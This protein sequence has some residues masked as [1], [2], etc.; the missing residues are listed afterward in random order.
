MTDKIT[1]FFFALF[2]RG[3]QQPIFYPFLRPHSAGQ[4]L[5]LVRLDLHSLVEQRITEIYMIE[6]TVLLFPCS[7]VLERILDGD[8]VRADRREYFPRK[9]QIFSEQLRIRDF[10]NDGNPFFASLRAQHSCGRIMKRTVQIV[11][12]SRADAVQSAGIEHT[13]FET[14]GKREVSRRKCVLA[15][16]GTINAAIEQLHHIKRLTLVE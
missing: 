9:N 3:K 4:N 12:L 15:E 8:G 14:F 11:P 13:S 1:A 16:K 5:F 7:G 6:N 2:R 10:R